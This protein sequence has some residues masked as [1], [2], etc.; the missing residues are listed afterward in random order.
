M[1]HTATRRAVLG[2]LALFFAA[3]GDKPSDT[4]AP[5]SGAAPGSK[6][7]GA[8]APATEAGQARE[9]KDAR[10]FHRSLGEPEYLDPNLISESEGGQVCHDTFE[11]LFQYGPNHKEWLPGVAETMETSPDGLTVTFKLRQNAKWSDG[12]PV[13]ARDFEYS[14]KRTLD[15]KTA[16]RYASF[17]WVLQGGKEYNESKEGPDRDK[18]RDAVG[19]KATD[20]YTLQVKLVGPIPYFQ[21]LTAFYTMAPVP[22]HVID[23]HGDQWARPEN[24]VSNGPWKVTEWKSQ[25]H[26]IAVKNEHYW[27][28]DKIPFDKVVF[29]ITQENQPAHNMYLAGQLDY[30]ESKVPES[31]LPRYLKEKNPEL[32]SS[33]YLG[34]YYYY[35]NT[36]KPPFN[37]AKVRQAL[38]LAIDKEKIGKFVVKGG[39]EAATSIVHP[40]LEELGYKPA[41]GSEYDPDQARKL[42]AEAGFPEGKGFPRFQISYNTLEGHKL[43]AEFIQQE[44]K[45]NLGIECDLDNMEWKVLLKKLNAK[46]YMVSRGAWIGDYLDPMT[47]LDLWEGPNSNNHTNWDHPE[48][49]R[50]I[51]DARKEADP[52]KRFDLLRQAEELFAKELPALPIY[53]YVKH[54][55]VKPWLKGYQSHLQ[56]IH[57]SRFFTIAQ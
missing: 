56:G 14:W 27:D 39:Q 1:K 15:P 54:D 51:A 5:S 35:I 38:S 30:L 50:L 41:K 36:A 6:A 22:K 52:N 32:K 10:V 45:N 42:L 53:F 31:V 4:P 40:K 57:P 25:Q 23:K 21:Q 47:F 16:S 19:V 43:I 2:L 8:K 9:E 44:W 7:Q 26:I 13:T 29:H 20:D 46:E 18:L 12:Q 34:V 55:M 17:L 49:N 33:P 3:C 48:F 28:K 37:D 24:I 11:G